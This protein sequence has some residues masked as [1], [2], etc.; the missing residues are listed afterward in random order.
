MIQNKN[1]RPVNFAIIV[2]LAN[3]SHEFHAFT[4]EL[5]R[6]LDELG[7][8]MIYFVIDKISLDNTLELSRELS[9]HD[10]RFVTVYEPLNKNIVDAYL[11][12]YREAYERG[13]EFIIEM[14]GGLSHDPKTIP[15][16]LDA[17]SQ[18]Y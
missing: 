3:E 11:R 1:M 7:F 4:V 5:I 17:F 10:K 6:I 15:L 9:G 16:F 12:G 14:D 8:G 18:G 2:P 13:H